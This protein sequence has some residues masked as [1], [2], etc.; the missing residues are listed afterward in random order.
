MSEHRQRKQEQKGVRARLTLAEGQRGSGAAE[1]HGALA[2]PGRGLADGAG[3]KGHGEC[4]EKEEGAC[5]K[6]ARKPVGL[7]EGDQVNG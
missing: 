1:H 7:K 2:R 6:A 5:A 4:C 3:E